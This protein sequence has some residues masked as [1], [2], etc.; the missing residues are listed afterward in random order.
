MVS[1]FVGLEAV[2]LST[3]RENQQQIL[4]IVNR[5]KV[6]IFPIRST[7]LTPEYTE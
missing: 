7:L 1:R 3:H 4:N 2:L 5:I 6:E